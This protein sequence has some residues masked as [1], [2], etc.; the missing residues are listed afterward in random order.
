MEAARGSAQPGPW[1][2]GFAVEG[3]GYRSEGAIAL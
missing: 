2:G 1:A 3:V